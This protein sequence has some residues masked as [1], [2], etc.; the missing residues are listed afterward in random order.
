M[1][2]GVLAEAGGTRRH[3]HNS[4]VRMEPNQ[5]LQP[6]EISI[7]IFRNWFK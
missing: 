4:C 2:G 5:L 3:L 7:C 1:T 6:P